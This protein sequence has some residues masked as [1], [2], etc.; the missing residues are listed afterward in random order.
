MR[1]LWSGCQ[2]SVVFSITQ[3]YVIRRFCLLEGRGPQ[4]SAWYTAHLQ[5]GPSELTAPISP[6]VNLFFFPLCSRLSLH[7]DVPVPLL[8]VHQHRPEPSQNACDDAALCPAHVTMP[9]MPGHAQQQDPPA[10]PPHTP[11]Q[12]GSRLC[13]QAH[14]HSKCVVWLPFFLISEPAMLVHAILSQ[15][16]HFKVTWSWPGFCSIGMY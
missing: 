1:A 8:Q 10:V 2:D 5:A 4:S 16:A 6:C 14:C 11:P 9:F 3:F 13:W 7:P 12:C 15:P